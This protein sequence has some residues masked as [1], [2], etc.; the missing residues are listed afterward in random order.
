MAC[1]DD[2]IEEIIPQAS[3]GW[4]NDKYIEY[5]R[6]FSELQARQNVLE[7][8]A[9]RFLSEDEF[10]SEFRKL[11]LTDR[12][13]FATTPFKP[14][15]PDYILASKLMISMC[16]YRATQYVLRYTTFSDRY[17]SG[18]DSKFGEV[19]Y[20]DND[21]SIACALNSILHCA[22][23]TQQYSIISFMLN[24]YTEFFKDTLTYEHGFAILPQFEDLK[25]LKILCDFGVDWN[26]SHGPNA[27]MVPLLWAL[28]Y[29]TEEAIYI[30]L[31]AG[32]SVHYQPDEAPANYL[33]A[34]FAYHC[35]VDTFPKYARLASRCKLLF[36]R[37]YDLHRLE[38][39]DVARFFEYAE[40]QP[41]FSEL[42]NNNQFLIRKTSPSGTTVLEYVFAFC[43]V[44][45]CENVLQYGWDLNNGDG[46][47][48]SLVGR[49]IF[50]G[51]DIDEKIKLLIESGSNPYQIVS[52]GSGDTCVECLASRK[53]YDL[54]E[55]VLVNFNPIASQYPES[56]FPT[57]SRLSDTSSKRNLIQQ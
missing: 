2:N 50:G 28:I 24:T 44:P 41:F 57:D 37:G 51:I 3:S 45:I 49:V 53:C 26:Y 12:R 29:Y 48:T 1:S 34:R 52:I 30:L 10:L 11:S 23:S 43:H 33:Y 27:L 25:L 13:I 54:L 38:I 21:E 7:K 6:C 20:W 46:R 42:L 14:C 5:T 31:D 19:K 32:A 8:V 18:Q 55:Y 22:I 47:R 36:D 4:F 40:F 39:Y 56:P 15:N 17:I 9:K 16:W 35:N